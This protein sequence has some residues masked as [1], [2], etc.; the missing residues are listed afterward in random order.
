MSS[1][2]ARIRSAGPNARN[3]IAMPTGISSPPPIPCTARNATS[4][5]SDVAIPQSADA[6]VNSPMAPSI[7]LLA[8][9]RSPTQPDAGIATASVTR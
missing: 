7:T 5:G 9:N 1:R 6:A 2:F 8:P 4:C 3:I